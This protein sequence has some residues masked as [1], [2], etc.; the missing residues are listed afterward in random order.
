MALLGTGLVQGLL[1]MH[2]LVPWSSRTHCGRSLAGCSLPTSLTLR[3][4]PCTK[5]WATGA[6]LI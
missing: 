6:L 3:L 5:T 4:S 2:M 1:Y